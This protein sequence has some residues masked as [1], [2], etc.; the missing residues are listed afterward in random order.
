MLAEFQNFIKNSCKLQ[1]GQKTLLAV[2][3]G[4]DSVVMLELFSRA[5]FPGIIAHCNFN[6]RSEESDGDE[7]FVKNFENRYN[8]KVITKNFDTTEFAKENKISIQMA[9]RQLRYEWFAE[10]KDL[11]SC[12]F[13]ATAHNKDDQIETF[14]INLTRG[15]G[16]KG[17]SGIKALSNGIIRPI[18]WA[19]RKTIVEYAK[20][21]ELSWREDSSNSSTKYLRNK[22]R[23]D[24]IPLFNEINPVFGDTMS[25]NIRKLNNV[26]I[27][28]SELIEEKKQKLLIKNADNWKISINEL[29]KDSNKKLILFE[30]LQEFNFSSGVVTDIFFSLS[31]SVE[32]GK[33]F[34][35]NDY[36]LIKDRDSLIIEL[37]KDKSLQRY[38]IEESDKEI[39]EPIH[40]SFSDIDINNFE[41]KKDSSIAQLDFDKLTFP[42]ILKK[43]QQGDYFMPLGMENLKKLSDFFI[44]NKLSI[45]EKEK[46]WILT[47]GKEIIWIVGMRID[48][49][50][51]VTKDTE[52][53][54]KIK[55]LR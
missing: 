4:I 1:T 45:P 3:G 2:S 31:N 38:Y 9:A 40:L 55:Y 32:S 54:L 18:L 35:S 6:L 22:I 44:D 5:E 34:Y 17:L 41:L 48:D 28:Y 27:L 19:E 12:D 8:Y 42:L 50:F 43:W 21:R 16:I 46:L 7:E 26:N 39:I 29:N 51:K 23:H 36:R 15:T 10:L 24:L 33:A 52:V 11:Y 14:F 53:V 20:D 37:K 30:I 13:I 47:S 49:R 25:E